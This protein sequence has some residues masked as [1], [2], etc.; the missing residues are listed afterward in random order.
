[1]YFVVT[2][3]TKP[4]NVLISSYLVRNDPV[5][6]ISRFSNDR[7]RLGN[8]VLANDKSYGDLNLA[9]CIRNNK[10]SYAV[11]IM[12]TK[13]QNLLSRRTLWPSTLS[14]SSAVRTKKQR[15]LKTPPPPT[16]KPTTRRKSL[17]EFSAAVFDGITI[18]IYY[19]NTVRLSNYF[20]WKRHS[21]KYRSSSDTWS[22][23][24][25]IQYYVYWTILYK[26]LLFAIRVR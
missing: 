9:R 22:T 6:G 11:A 21:V 3:L 19:L 23:L 8:L 7:D 5:V 10:T 16:C 18:L 26:I 24:H 4:E 14:D 2:V 13:N 15:A 1:M 12:K 25:L 20:I 17:L